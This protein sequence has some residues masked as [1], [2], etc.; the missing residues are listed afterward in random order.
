M[1]DSK[2]HLEVGTIEF[3]GEGTPEW[4]SSQWDKIIKQIPE[5]LKSTP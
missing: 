5:L 4:V 2:I 3:S 1:A